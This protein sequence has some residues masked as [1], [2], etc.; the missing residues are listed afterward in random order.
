MSRPEYDAAFEGLPYPPVLLRQMRAVTLEAGLRWSPVKRE[1]LWVHGLRHAF[2]RYALWCGQEVAGSNP[3][4]PTN[5]QDMKRPGV[6]PGPSLRDASRM[7]D[8]FS[9]LSSSGLRSSR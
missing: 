7:F 5:Q 1:R 4:A 9:G 8:R 2:G 3:V 6:Y